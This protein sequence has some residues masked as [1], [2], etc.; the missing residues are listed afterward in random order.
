M[1]HNEMMANPIRHIRFIGYGLT[2]AW[3]FMLLF[4]PLLAR[5]IQR[6]S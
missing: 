5:M 3:S 4:V 2:N 6:S 1:E